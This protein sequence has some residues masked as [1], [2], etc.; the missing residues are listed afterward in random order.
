MRPLTLEEKC[1]YWMASTPGLGYRHFFDLLSEE[2]ELEEFFSR[3]RQIPFEKHKIPG[4]IKEELIRRANMDMIDEELEGMAKKGISAIPMTHPS[5]PRHLREISRA[6][7]LLYCKGDLERLTERAIGFVG[8]RR[9]SRKGQKVAREIAE[10]LAEAGV[11]IVSG[12]ARGI[13]SAAH[14]GAL[15]A[16]GATVAVLGCGV[17]VV[18]PKENIELY[19]AMADAGAVISEYPPGMPPLPGHFPARNRIISGIAR[20]IAVGECG[21]KSGVQFTVRFA[22]ENDRD[23]F[24]VEG[25]GQEGLV[26]LPGQLIE[27]GAFPCSCAADILAYYGW[28]KKIE[29][30]REPASLIGLD[31]LEQELYNL[32]LKGDRTFEQLAAETGCRANELN[33]V[34]TKLEIKGLIVRLAGNTLGIK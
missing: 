23:I 28:K 14:W 17:D 25:S 4:N 18:Y 12:M 16:K 31:F 3:P 19:E 27:N 2:R 1:W 32:L 29:E 5:Y 24:V 21:I 6:P 15:N 8:T 7:L 10:G 33:I 9:C 22:M 34:I 13:D 30:K 20:G 26:E 11:T